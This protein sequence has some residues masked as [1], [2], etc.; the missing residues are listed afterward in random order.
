MYVRQLM[1]ALAIF[2]TGASS[3]DPPKN[4]L[5]DFTDSVIPADAGIQMPRTIVDRLSL[6]K[7]YF[8]S[9][10]VRKQIPLAR[11]QRFNRLLAF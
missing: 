4:M 6:S 7:E 8:S 3:Y 11:I 9:D 1:L 5:V 2:R 10:Q